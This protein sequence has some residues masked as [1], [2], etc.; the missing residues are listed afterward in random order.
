MIDK[1]FY[2]DNEIHHNSNIKKLKNIQYMELSIIYILHYP[3][4]TQH[5]NLNN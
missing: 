1:F 2:L 4:R 3:G 5:G